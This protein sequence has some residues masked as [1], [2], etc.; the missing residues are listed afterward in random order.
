M[1]AGERLLVI[2][3]GNRDRG[4][5][6]VG[7]IVCDMVEQL[8]VPQVDTIVFEGSA[9]DLPLRWSADDRVVIVDAAEPAGEPGLIS[10]TDALSARLVAPGPVSTHTI[11][12]GAAVE[13]ARALDRLPAELTIIGI[14]GAGFE[15]GAPLTLAVQQAAHQVVATMIR[16]HR[17]R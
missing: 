16:R 8:G 17:S 3:V 12:V 4:D 9:L 13:L 1:S 2:G 10:T 11:D 5:D 7:P 14:E 6:A 15:F